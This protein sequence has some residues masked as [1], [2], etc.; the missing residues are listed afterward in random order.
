MKQTDPGARIAVWSGPR[1]IS[2]ALMRSWGS[3]RDTHVCDEPFYAH[4]LERTGTDHPGR[5]EV[6]AHHEADW[7]KV[8]SWLTGP[9]P[10]GR[11]IFYQKHM[12]HHL[13]PEIERGWLRKLRNVLLIRSPTEMLP[14]L[15]RFLPEPTAADTGLPQQWE[16]FGHLRQDTGHPPPVIDSRDVLEDPA[17]MLA[18]LC[19][20]VK[21]PYSEEMLSW[22]T[23]P[24]KTD[25]VWAKHW[26]AVVERSTGFAPYRA[27]DEPV[28]DRL[29]PVHEECMKFYRRLH[30]RRLQPE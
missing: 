30:G 2:T 8:V 5:E 12:A 9:V 10:E 18:A 16:L 26:Y 6:L 17:G 4:Y 11:P 15:V 22:E 23:G 1:N 27:R 13:L 19:R 20:A 28:A 25:G 29:R 14:S 21:V 7:R 24:R 3:R